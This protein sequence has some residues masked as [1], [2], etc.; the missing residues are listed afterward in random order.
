MTDEKTVA[1]DVPADDAGTEEESREALFAEF[2][3]EDAP[4]GRRDPSIVEDDD[5]A[6]ESVAPDDDEDGDG[7]GAPDDA[8]DADDADDEGPG[9][10]PAK[11]KAQIEKLTHQ[12]ASEKGRT[13]GQGRKIATLQREIESIRQAN[14]RRSRDDDGA[15]K[16]RTER[17]AKIRED[18]PD[19]VEPLMAE[20]ED[21]KN[22]SE[23]LSKREEARL[24]DLEA[25]RDAIFQRE[26][27]AFLEEHEDG[28]D[29]ISDNADTFRAWIDDQPRRLR[30]AFAENRETITNG[31]SAALLISAFKQSL[32]AAGQEPPH[33]G[34]TSAK[35][36]DTTDS[37]RQRQLRGART[38]A[39]GKR[40]A[41]TSDEPP[42]GA[43]REEWFEYF[44]KKDSARG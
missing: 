19:L 6:E 21:L 44:A 12:L 4:D 15:Q 17:L 36:N 43:S 14:A 16:D 41:V 20:I 26:E 35:S 31:T 11:L 10:D 33:N 38:T 28:F 9:D 27:E 13:S 7:D 39:S 42:P 2:T 3:A 18:Y 34:G 40:N 37:R 32:Q 1:E 25:E 8:D 24:G 30:D 5:A 29:V 22:R 23:A